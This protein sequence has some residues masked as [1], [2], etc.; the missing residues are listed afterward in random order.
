MQLLIPD[1]IRYV[2]VFGVLYYIRWEDLMPG[3]SV[4]IKTT[5]AA[6]VVQQAVQ[7]AEKFLRIKLKAHPRCESGYY[8]VRVWRVN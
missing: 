6:R 7:P 4:F 3:Y 5:A 8:G 1:H 2:D